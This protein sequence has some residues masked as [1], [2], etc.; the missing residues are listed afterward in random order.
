M[1]AP[2]QPNVTFTKSTDGTTT[3]VSKTSTLPNG[4][5]SVQSFTLVQLNAMVANLN[6][7]Y[8]SNLAQ[9]NSMI[10]LLTPPATPVAG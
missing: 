3:W 5:A 4:Q 9:L 7:S 8:Q 10:A 6:S 2:I 1:P